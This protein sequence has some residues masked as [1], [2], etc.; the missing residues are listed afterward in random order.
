MAN[1]YGQ[2]VGGLLVDA[3]GDVYDAGA[4]LIN[5]V[6]ENP[7]A[8]GLMAG[9]LAPGAGTADASG[10]YPDPM[11]PSQNLPSM[12]Q[13]IAQGEYLDAGF[14]GLGLLGDAAI[15]VPPLAAALKAPRA[16][17][18]ARRGAKNADTSYRMRH[19]PRAPQDGAARLDEMTVAAGNEGGVFPED[20]YS[21]DGLRFYGNPK[22]KADQ[23]SH[24]IIR[25]VRGNSDAK[26]TIYRA[27]PKGVEDINEG[28]FVTLS[29]EY[30]E[31][32]AASG[33]GRNGD[34]AGQVI[35]MEVE[36]RDLYSEGND[37]NEFGFFPKPTPK[38]EAEE[39][40]RSVLD[41]LETGQ[42]DQIDAV[43]LRNADDAYLAQNYDLPMDDKSRMD[44]ARDMGF[45]TSTVF[46]RGQRNP[47]LQE[48]PD[49][50]FRRSPLFTSDDP[51][52][53]SS[54]MPHFGNI[55]SGEDTAR[56]VYEPEMA[57][58]GYHDTVRGS[59]GGSIFPLFLRADDKT[60]HIDTYGQ[61]YDSI[62][63]E[64]GVYFNDGSQK[65][66]SEIYPSG[67][68]IAEEVAD[69]LGRQY[70]TPVVHFDGLDDVGY[71]PE[72]ALIGEDGEIVS[73][74]SGINTTSGVAA[75]NDPTA[76]RSI[77]ARFDPRLKNLSNL[78][79]GMLI[80]PVGGAALAGGLL[81]TPTKTDEGLL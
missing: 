19:Q 49:S 1:I 72:N 60:A 32:H 28:D 15:A 68:L 35:K 41:M 55:M 12:R 48:P 14:Q 4:G 23:E 78:N 13:N 42:A 3:A 57:L 31:Q 62:D 18:V 61:N 34:E 58:G 40:A 75:I 22:S 81:S 20:L 51:D 65:S 77:F 70:K 21:D 39:Q 79:A 47:Y 7:Q 76:M 67:S 53:A 36:A 74:G 52:V 6:R 54:Y 50:G 80:A 8:A 30:A 11:N 37:L 29:K 33:Y 71:N 44:R 16:I 73:F 63:E 5:F 64:A 46:Y 26:V 43:D 2:T 24:K 10:A 56:I 45:D 27:V 59:D 66:L 25:S 17:Q 9:Q 69:Q 38:T